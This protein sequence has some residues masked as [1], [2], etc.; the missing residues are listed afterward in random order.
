MIF[1]AAINVLSADDKNLL[2]P[3]IGF[4][5]FVFTSVVPFSLLDT[6]VIG[7]IYLFSFLS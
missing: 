2:L 7:V 5:A 1:F 3:L 6:S 4:S